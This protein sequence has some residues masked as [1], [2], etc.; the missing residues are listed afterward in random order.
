MA[1]REAVQADLHLLG[2]H[3]DQQGLGLVGDQALLPTEGH[4]HRVDLA[5]RLLAVAGV[6]GC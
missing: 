4:V 5:D 6:G 1:H 3:H 2:A